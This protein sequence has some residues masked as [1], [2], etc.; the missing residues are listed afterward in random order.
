VQLGNEGKG[1]WEGQC[2]GIRSPLQGLAGEQFSQG[3]AL[4]WL[5]APLW[6]WETMK[7]K[8]SWCEVQLCGEQGDVPKCNLGTRER[9]KS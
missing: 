6:G 1:K 3:V 2:K 9:Q 5:R 4:G 7:Q 8:G